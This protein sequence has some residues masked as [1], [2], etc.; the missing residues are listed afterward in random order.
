MHVDTEWVIQSSVQDYYFPKTVEEIMKVQDDAD[1]IYWNSLNYL[2]HDNVPLDCK[3]EIRK[4]DWGNFAVRSHL[5][6]RIDI[7]HLRDFQ[8][9]GEYVEQLHEKHPAMRSVKIPKILT[10]HV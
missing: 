4:I 5:A 3:P 6:K 2:F 7:K 8:A 10:V 1:F 9:D